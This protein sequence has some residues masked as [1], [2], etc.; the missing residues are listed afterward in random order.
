MRIKEFLP[1]VI[2]TAKRSPICD[3]PEIVTSRRTMLKLRIDLFMGGLIQVY[4]NE[5]SN[6]ISFAYILDHRRRFAIDSTGGWHRHPFHNPALH[7][8]L[9]REVTFAEFLAE[10]EKHLIES[11]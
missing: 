5:R 2:D 4:V 3:E 11:E 10:V 9:S 6:T 7:D 1:D 8:P